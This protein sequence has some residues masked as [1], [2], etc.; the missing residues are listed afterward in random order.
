MPEHHR[1]ELDDLIKASKIRLGAHDQPLR[2]ERKN[3]KV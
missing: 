1:D 3:G 2:L